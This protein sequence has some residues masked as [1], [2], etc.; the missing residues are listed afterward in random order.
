[1]PKGAE[2]IRYAIYTRQSKLG[3]ADF[4]SC[5]AQFQICRK[6]A[7]QSKERLRFRASHHF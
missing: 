2:R 3:L 5:D 6:H 1:M 4:S 7:R